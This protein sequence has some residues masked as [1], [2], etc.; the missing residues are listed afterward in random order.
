MPEKIR[1][2]KKQLKGEDGYKTFS[3][4][5]KDEF[6]DKLNCIAIE[7]GMSRNEIISIFIQYGI[8]NYEVIAKD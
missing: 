7:T 5:I 6:V 8:E 4:R 3:I 2:V 1:L